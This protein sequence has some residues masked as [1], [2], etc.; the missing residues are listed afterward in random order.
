MACPNVLDILLTTKYFEDLPLH[1][2]ETI[3]VR[4]GVVISRHTLERQVMHCDESRIQL[5][6]EPDR[7]PTNQSWM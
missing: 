1:Q 5:L 3:L 4:H 2:L 7:D 6:N